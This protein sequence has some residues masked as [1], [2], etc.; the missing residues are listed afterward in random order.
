MILSLVQIPCR[1]SQD[2]PV[3]FLS[4]NFFPTYCSIPLNRF[5]PISSL[6]DLHPLPL[7]LSFSLS[8]NQ[9]IANHTHP[10]SSCVNRADVN[11]T[12]LPVRAARRLS[13]RSA[14]ASAVRP[15]RCG[16]RRALPVRLARSVR[17]AHRAPSPSLV[18]SPSLA[19]S[20][21]RA[22]SPSLARNPSL[23]PSRRPVQSPSRARP[24]RPALPGRNASERR[25]SA[26]LSARPSATI[27][28]ANQSRCDWASFYGKVLA[29]AEIGYWCFHPFLGFGSSWSPSFWL[30]CVLG[31]R[32]VLVLLFLTSAVMIL[33][34]DHV[35]FSCFSSF[36]F[37]F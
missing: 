6:L 23:V 14:T 4:P 2:P 26:R 31:S 1:S 8:S 21:S 24:L 27:P 25:K 9:I 35:S 3:L 36:L 11:Q 19:L 30:R 17:R 29:F 15:P 7:R 32:P 34:V 16:A 33:F 18:P 22:L 5:H 37:C 12:A 20:P 28:A 13:R 10:W